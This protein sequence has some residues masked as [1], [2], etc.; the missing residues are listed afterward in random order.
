[1]ATIKAVYHCHGCKRRVY[2]INLRSKRQYCSD[3][4]RSLYL[5]HIKKR[6]QQ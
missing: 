2:D 4:C 5:T 1:M 6:K 3:T